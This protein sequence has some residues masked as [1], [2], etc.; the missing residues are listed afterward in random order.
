[1]KR[2]KILLN[3]I[4]IILISIVFG[5][6]F[7]LTN[8][9]EMPNWIGLQYLKLGFFFRLIT[10]ISLPFLFYN[11]EESLIEKYY[12]KQKSLDV[13]TFKQKQWLIFTYIFL[14]IFTLFSFNLMLFSKSIFVYLFTILCLLSICFSFF[15]TNNPSKIETDKAIIFNQFSF[16]IKGK[17]N[18]S[19][20]EK[21]LNI[22]NPF[23]GILGIASTGSGKT[24][25]F[26]EPCIEQYAFKGYSGILFDFKFPTL[27][28]I[29]HLHFG[30][31]DVLSFQ[32]GE[33]KFIKNPT[34]FYVINFTDIARSHRINPLNPKYIK[35]Q[36]YA[37][38]FAEAI[39]NSL[40]KGQNHSDKFFTPSAI[41]LL[42]AIIWFLKK[43]Y[44]QYCTFPH[45]V[46]LIVG[47]SYEIL[48]NKL[49]E[50]EECASL[51]RSIITAID[52]KA[53]NQ[54]AGVIASLQMP[55]G[56][57]NIPEFMYV[58]SGDDTTID[59]NEKANPKVICMG[60]AP[61]IAAAL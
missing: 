7:V 43:H 48:I 6:W 51:I 40:Q 47:D 61:D 32:K 5:E 59:V 25:S 41:T 55:F 44:P 33:F 22:V 31:K 30:R 23:R 58:L 56:T 4:A 45:V 34:N 20:H 37:K 49:R 1:M 39:I 60:T 21:W 12:Q 10:F 50:D 28:N 57:M 2:Q 46:N 26:V 52:S 53:S 24:V 18:N 14:A 19:V 16:N 35:N 17:R 15:R 54:L 3:I 13:F 36:I 38:E 29:A 27:S 9:Q 42:T 8:H 11:Q